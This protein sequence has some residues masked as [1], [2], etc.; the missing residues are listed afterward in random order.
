M[1]S[2]RERRRRS[3]NIPTDEH[4]NLTVINSGKVS[5]KQQREKCFCGVYHK[6]RHP[7]TNNDLGT[8][9]QYNFGEAMPPEMQTDL[10]E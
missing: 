1:E 6:K 7:D 9:K 8:Y 10:S 3:E 5:G 4:G 2:V